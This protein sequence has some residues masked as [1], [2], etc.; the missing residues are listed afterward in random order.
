MVSSCSTTHILSNGVGP[1]LIAC[2]VHEI[3]CVT[4]GTSFAYNGILLH[5]FLDIV[6][7]SDTDSGVRFALT[8]TVQKLVYRRIGPFVPLRG[9]SNGGGPHGL[10]PI[11]Y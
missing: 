4:Y 9:H 3:W 8:L 1:M 5:V 10:S 6:S 7:R 11:P 2:L